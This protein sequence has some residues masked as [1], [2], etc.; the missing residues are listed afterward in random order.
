MLEIPS[1][2]H[3]ARGWLLHFDATLTQTQDARRLRLGRHAVDRPAAMVP[4]YSG[5]STYLLM[6]KYNNY[7]RRRT[8]DGMNQLA[9]LDPTTTPGR[10]DLGRARS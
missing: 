7:A 4:S 10:P 5:P 6:T 3:N 2:A 8:G 1:A 9:I